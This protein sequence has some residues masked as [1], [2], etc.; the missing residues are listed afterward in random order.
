MQ[1]V[2][3][4]EGP[5]LDARLQGMWRPLLDHTSCP[6]STAQILEELARARR[7]GEIDYCLVYQL[8]R[9]PVEAAIDPPGWAIH[10]VHTSH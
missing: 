7:S 3:R 8:D 1:A 6:R 5:E 9:R 4:L 10:V 2:L